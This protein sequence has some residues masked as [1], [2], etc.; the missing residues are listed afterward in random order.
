[1]PRW[2]LKWT[3]TED[4]C[5]TQCIYIPPPP[6]P[7]PRTLPTPPRPP[8]KVAMYVAQWFFE[9]PGKEAFKK[10]TVPV[11][12]A[13]DKILLRCA[14]EVSIR[15]TP[16]ILAVGLERCAQ[17]S[18]S[19]NAQV[20]LRCAS[21]E[22]VLEAFAFLFLETVWQIWFSFLF[23]CFFSPSSFLSPS[24]CCFGVACLRFEKWNPPPKKAVLKLCAFESPQ[25]NIFF[26]ATL[27]LFIVFDHKKSSSS[28]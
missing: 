6:N 17:M 24:F 13:G 14:S 19:W 9:V 25:K 7:V 26:D 15:H 27:F 3:P 4:Q 20:N 10:N 21:K 28:R 12:C 23:P 1:M 8:P 11:M 16:I 22:K 2:N 5:D 18:Q